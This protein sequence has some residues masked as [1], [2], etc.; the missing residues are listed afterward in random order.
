MSHV[1]EHNLLF[2]RRVARALAGRSRTSSV[3]EFEDLVQAGVV[4]LLEAEARFDPDRGIAFRAFALK[5][6]VGAMHDELRR[7]NRAPTPVVSLDAQVSPRSGETFVD[8]IAQPADPGTDDDASAIDAL[9]PFS[10]LSE[11][12]R[13]VLAYAAAGYR[14]TEIGAMMKISPTRVRQLLDGV[15]SRN[16]TSDP[17][18]LSAREREVLAATAEGL[19]AKEVADRLSI[20]PSTVRDHRRNAAGKLGAR[21]TTHAVA[22]A[23]EEGVLPLSSG[24]VP[25]P[26]GR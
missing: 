20:S 26:N 3:L 15:A 22:V 19:T 18:A 5:R 17:A 11:R 25:A 1:V 21:N 9:P 13:T 7:A 12:R 2:V 23:Y 4:G 14:V 16:A 10:L 6:V 24:G 8:T